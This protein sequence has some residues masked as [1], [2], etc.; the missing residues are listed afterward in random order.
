MLPFLKNK[1]EAAAMGDE[2]EAIT[3]KHDDE[4][5]DY[6]MLDAIVED[7]INAVKKENRSLLKN[8]LE[9]LIEHIKEEDKEQDNESFNENRGI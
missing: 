1:K 5:S 3:R 4:S 6:E 8:A 2:D 9:A 7:I